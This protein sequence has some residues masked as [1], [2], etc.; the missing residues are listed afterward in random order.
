MK[1]S[2]NFYL[3]LVLLYFYLIFI[4]IWYFSFTR[5]QGF[6]LTTERKKIQFSHFDT[7]NNLYKVIVNKESNFAGTTIH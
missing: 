6:S 7:F 5:F 3:V 4:T 2:L 1:I